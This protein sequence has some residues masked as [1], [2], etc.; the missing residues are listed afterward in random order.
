MVQAGGKL[1]MQTMSQS[2]AELVR[3][4]KIAREEAFNR[5]SAPEELATLLGPA[6]AVAPGGAVHA[7]GLL[8]SRR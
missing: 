1:G 3:S 7:T 6:G 4:G 5:T 2:L 8:G